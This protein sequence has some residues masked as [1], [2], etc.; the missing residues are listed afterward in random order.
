MCSRS[1]KMRA[2]WRGCRSRLAPPP[3]S[4]HVA[5]P[6]TKLRMRRGE[7]SAR[8]AERATERQRTRRSAEGSGG[9]GA[10]P[11]MIF[12][13]PARV[14]RRERHFRDL[15]VHVSRRRQTIARRRSLEQSFVHHCRHNPIDGACAGRLFSHRAAEGW[16]ATDRARSVTRHGARGATK[17]EWTPHVE[18]NFEA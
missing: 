18:Q 13:L 15:A 11:W 17:A 9:R 3:R 10:L 7:Q 2:S 14:D 12:D 4:R 6:T 1:Q 16:G 8:E 5:M